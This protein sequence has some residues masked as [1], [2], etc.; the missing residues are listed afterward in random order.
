MRVWTIPNIL[1]FFRLL[2]LVPIIRLLQEGRPWPALI[3][4]A[5]SVVTDFL[6]G[7][8]ARRF[9]QKSDLGRIM[10]PI[11]DKANVLGVMAVLVL[12]PR[13]DYPLWFFALL[14]LR[15]LAV[16][17]G[18]LWVMR[19]RKVVMEAT[20]PGKNSAFVTS[21]TVPL[22]ILGLQPWAILSVYLALALNVYSTTVYTRR[23]L[24]QLK[25][26]SPSGSSMAEGDD[27]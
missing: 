8:I 19:G 24:A 1:S 10:D 7:F 23:F 9:D 26:S 21:M 2:L 12:S 20:R 17:V 6:D 3:L 15:E 4:M 25:Q 18:G 11:I 14:F 5:T 13:Y 22:Y 16:L 27:A